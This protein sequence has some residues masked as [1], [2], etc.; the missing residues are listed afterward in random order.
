MSYLWKKLGRD[1]LHL[2]PQ[3][4]SVFMMALLA[5]AIYS[6]MEGVW[7]G[8]LNQAENYF[9]ETSLADVWVYS[10]GTDQVA[11]DKIAEKKDVDAAAGSMTVLWND[12][13][14]K[15]QSDIRVM[16]LKDLNVNN[17]LL[18]TGTPFEEEEK[19][20]WLADSYAKE[21]GIRTGDTISMECKG[22][23]VSVPVQGTIMDSEFIYY[24]T[25]SMEVVPD[26]K[27]HGYGIISEAQALE[28]YGTISYNEIRLKLSDGAD[29]DQIQDEVAAVLGDTQTAFLERKDKNS[30]YQV[31]KEAYQMRVLSRAYCTLFLLL[32]I[33]TMYTTMRRLVQNQNT[34]IGTLKAMGFSDRVLLVH[35]AMYGLLVSILG[36]V[37]GCLLGRFVISGIIMS[38][39]EKT[40]SIPVWKSELSQ[41]T[42][43]MA[44]GVVAVCTFSAVWAARHSMR[45][46]PAEMMRQSVGAE[47]VMSKH[48]GRLR[49][50]LS[51]EWTWVFR[52]ISRN[53]VRYLM[54]VLGMMGSVALMMAGF[55]VKNSLEYSSDCVY[56]G[57]YSYDY[58]IQGDWSP[59]DKDRLEQSVSQ[60]QWV[61]EKNG[62]VKK[63][64]KRET[65]ACT[66]IGEG[67]YLSLTDAQG[68]KVILP[69]EGG[70]ISQKTAE[71][72]DVK[73]GD[74][75]QVRILG[76]SQKF[77]IKISNIVT[78]P[79]PQGIFLSQ[80]AWEKTGNVF[81]GDSALTGSLN[82][83]E[84]D[85]WQIISLKEQQ[86]KFA[87]FS[88]ALTIIFVMLIGA[89]LLLG[90]VILY[91]LGMLSFV[92]RYR[93]YATMKV[94]GFYAGEIR[95]MGIR[96]W[97]LTSI[98]GWAAGSVLGFWFLRFITGLVSMKSFVF[99]PKLDLKWYL[100]ISLISLIGSLG[101]NLSV[102]L[103]ADRIPMV[104][105]LKSVE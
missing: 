27:L 12:T 43:L 57:V 65:A 76:S 14:G 47:V 2:W 15:N 25:S 51:N 16:T 86:S 54:G 36:S 105:A 22:R 49:S 80:E 97:F 101:I 59:Q 92:E 6:G 24:T 39:K 4:V 1:M 29:M 11:V 63:G 71:L 89:S 95:G 69:E 74:G 9:E 81:D 56:G 48:T 93:E 68:E 62:I 46:M 42:Y 83:K 19:G 99:F 53:K 28:W 87:E 26:K 103:R 41:N 77:E 67:N 55:G 23:K 79:A 85:S 35:Y 38:V 13:E 64:E 104:D 7:Y 34:L 102:S 60:V 91:N 31:Y 40:L 88:R 17:P 5:L 66:I 50:R 21:H 90:S 75:V 58:R 94:L 82:P 98:P 45:G 72:L 61:S 37:C 8:L 73:V 78:V 33:L 100:L 96:D 70:V 18:M 30:V 32:S 44:V 84:W 3:F 10:T 20:I 52:D